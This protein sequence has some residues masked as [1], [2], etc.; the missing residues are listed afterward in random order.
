MQIH[1]MCRSLSQFTD[2]SCALVVGGNK[3]LKAQVWYGVVC[4]VLGRPSFGAAEGPPET[5]VF[6]S[7][8]AVM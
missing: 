4:E 7:F 3:N 6:L 5:N 2:I 1:S 8:L